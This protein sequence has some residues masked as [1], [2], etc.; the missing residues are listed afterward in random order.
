MGRSSNPGGRS[1]RPPDP[2]LGRSLHRASAMTRETR[3][4]VT[5]VDRVARLWRRYGAAALAVVLESAF[6]CII[7]F[8]HEGRI[9]E[10]NQAAEQTFGCPR[11][12][13]AGRSFTDIVLLPRSRECPHL[14]V[15]HDFGT[16]PDSLLGKRMELTGVRV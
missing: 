1:L 5:R 6:D 15:T 4:P 3:V 11:L 12:E 13:L 7:T 9:L 10:L 2:C 16:G 8:D 14:G